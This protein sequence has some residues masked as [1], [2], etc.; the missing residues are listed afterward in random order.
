MN[1]T[2]NRTAPVRVMIVDDDAM[3]RAA[4]K[5]YSESAKTVGEDGQPR[6]V[7][8]VVAEAPDGI[9]AVRLAVELKPDVVLIDLRMPNMDGVT[10]IRQMRERGVKAG[11]I[12]M[13]SFDT[14]DAIL[15]SV[16][17]GADGFLAKDTSP[18][19]MITAVASAA[20]GSGWF[21]PRAAK[22][23]A[24]QTRSGG[25]RTPSSEERR[26]VDT[27][28]SQELATTKLLASGLTNA[29]IAQELHVGQS[30]IK[31]Y[32]S[33]AMEKTN[34]DNRVRLAVFASRAGLEIPVS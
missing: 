12:A 4:V 32:V 28:T 33:N 34:T 2:P 15:D 10:A 24:E 29:E 27:L 25:T 23:I 18:A 22:I 9:E 8:Q 17:A 5:I 21:S 30:T 13:T 16:D 20:E 26:L 19:A 7:N 1:L 3:V 31:T 6:P 14:N 11:I